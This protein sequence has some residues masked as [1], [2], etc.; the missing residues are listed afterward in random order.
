MSQD[1]T[2]YSL[3]VV[4]AVGLP[5]PRFHKAPMAYVKIK[6]SQS[7][8]MRTKRANPTQDPVWDEKFQISVTENPPTTVLLRVMHELS[9]H[10]NTCLGAYNIELQSLAEMANS[11]QERKLK[12]A[13]PQGKND[14]RDRGFIFIQVTRQNVEEVGSTAIA[15]AAA[16][17]DAG[18]IATVAGLSDPR[19]VAVGT[20][21][22]DTVS[23]P[24]SLATAVI[25]L[26]SKLEVFVNVIDEV[27]KIHP[28]VNI[29]WKITSSLYTAVDGQIER[30][31]DII[32]L[33]DD[34][35][36]VY[37]FVDATKE[38]G[39]KIQL[40]EDTV[41]SILKQ[42]VECVA[43]I[44]EYSGKG[45][46]E[47]LIKQTFSNNGERISKFRQKFIDLRAQFDSGV[48]IETAIVSFRISEGIAK[49]TMNMN[50]RPAEMNASSRGECQ[51]DTRHDIITFVA[52]WL[53]NPSPQNVLWLHGV[54]GS[55]KSTIATTIANYFRRLSRLGA[56]LFFDRKATS[57]PSIVIRT[58]AYK[59]ALFNPQI[60][61]AVSAAIESNCDI[62][63]LPLAQ[64][65]SKLFIEPLSQCRD[66][67]SE[68]SIIVILDAL[69]ECG[70]LDSR[71]QLLKPLVEGLK[72][73]PSF[74]RIF[75]TSRRQPDISDY[76]DGCAKIHALKL[77]ITAESNMKDT[78]LYLQNMLANIQKK[79]AFS[80]EWPTRAQVDALH[81]QSA[82]LFIWCSTAMKF[83]DHSPY[84]KERLNTLL[85][86]V[87]KCSAEAALDNLYQIALEE[88]GLGNDTTDFQTI[89]GTII[90]AKEPLL[91][92]TIDKL[93]G[94][95]PSHP[96]LSTIE[97]FGCVVSS[98]AKEPVCLLHPSFA[99]YLCDPNRCKNKNWF[100]NTTFHHHVLAERCFRVMESGE[101]GDGNS[102][103]HFNICGLVTSYQYNNDVNNLD[104]HVREAIYPSLSY[105][106]RFWANH[107]H[108]TSKIDSDHEILWQ[109]LKD[110]F[111]S[112]LLYWV[113]ALSL[114]NQVSI[115]PLMLQYVSDWLQDVDAELSAFATD[116]RRFIITFQEP[117]SDS[118]PH[119]YLSA[120]PFSPMTSK[121]R[122]QYIRHF[123]NTI[124]MERGGL[125][126]WPTNIK[127]LEGHS[128]GV[129]SVAFS[130]DGKYIVSGSWDT[131]VRVW[132]TETGQAVSV[133]F[134]GHSSWVTS[135][136][137][138]PDGKHIASGSDDKT[139]RV[140][141]AETGQAVGASFD[142]HS[143]TVTSVAF[144]PNGKHI[145]SGSWDTTIC[146]WDVETGQAVS[147]PFE[148]H[149][150]WVTSVAFSPDGK[151]IVSGSDDETLRV[152]DAETGK[153]SVSFEGHSNHI[154]SVA[155]SPDG[156]YIASGSYDKTVRVWNADTGKVSAPFEGHSDS[157]T[158]VAF[159]PDGKHIV[160][161]SWDTTVCVWDVATGIAASAPFEGHSG[162]VTSVE[163]SPDGKYI[164]S[165]SY[166]KT[167]YIWDAETGQAVSASDGHS[168]TVSSVAFSPNG[169][170]IASGSYDTTIHVWD[171][172]T[173]QAVSA[174]FKGHSDSV[175]SVAFSSD[176]KYIV[177][178][179]WDTTIRVWD[180]ETGMATSEPFEGHSETVMSVA[181]SPDGKHI[182]SGSDDETGRIWDAETGQTVFTLFEGH[183]GSLRS[184]AFSPDGKHIVSGLYNGTVC[185]W[186]AETGQAVSAPFEGHSGSIR[187]V[188]FSPDGKHIVSGSYD[189]TVCIWDVETGQAVSITFQGHSGTVTSVAFSSN[190][191]YIVSGS[192]DK[193]IRVWDA[194]TGQVVCAPLEGHSGSVTSVA[195]SP[196]GTHIVSG[197]FDKTVHLSIPKTSL[198]HLLHISHFHHGWM[199]GINSELLFWVP[200]DC[201]TAFC[202]G[203]N[204][205]V[206]GK[207]ST[208]LDFSNFVHGHFWAQCHTSI[209]GL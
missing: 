39:K 108:T 199:H 209:K 173:G 207:H 101:N 45:F 167:I 127:V 124:S 113:E 69:D 50:L 152:W 109:Y 79:K 35:K 61:N 13:D 27:S 18:G 137:F 119:I 87:Q 29:A 22:V 38:L 122:E 97:Y 8:Q 90:C 181:F 106:C 198:I 195:F 43:F 171:A 208:K 123:Q 142:G 103:L 72:R 4:K 78:W 71:E 104:A 99:D 174:P 68:G 156:K 190:G 26:V 203:Q 165:G 159:S 111:N 163:F 54:A 177:S 94:F 135:V 179:S 59:L 55:G 172:E 130:S 47:R 204:T 5:V 58:L 169:K 158:S 34:M 44:L 91:P 116:A 151:Y 66:L 19:L 185:V 157:V 11:P 70:N 41:S 63:E 191:K 148:G 9:T 20:T 197:S 73:L 206:M 52:H 134:E 31:V 42:T 126:A 176:G 170:H 121:V 139:I 128:V 153:A 89:F 74:L 105:S 65:V 125:Y 149:S 136:A 17:I 194:K 145:I 120:L 32:Q 164:I 40:L 56:F 182:V 75:I 62:T 92:K 193:T 49:L 1:T 33:V 183:R 46:G 155:F 76:F 196:D 84:P 178:G 188:A 86:D 202:W 201:R 24:R 133:P 21:M 143:G 3:H 57:D 205:A 12:L 15:D 160:S 129:T 189:E 81:A 180:V 98:E 107:L 25:G 150:G 184:V 186:D 10:L 14:G 82:G 80:P 48:N 141:D 146:I 100:I 37:S 168:G 114:L 162:W 140:W 175:T 110:F 93:L 187:S 51:P 2:F 6:A 16:A 88:S 67:N 85:V 147:A 192:Y 161:G 77:D 112:R 23:N 138:S 118:T 83:I 154:T 36:D 166:D 30:D 200:P 95:D 131:T 7:L 115:A 60:W 53:M 102:G 132:D 144:S 64:Q 117:I 28:Y 96:C